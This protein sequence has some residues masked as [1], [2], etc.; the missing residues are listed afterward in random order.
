MNH[1]DTKT[2]RKKYINNYFVPLS[3]SGC[4]VVIP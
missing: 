2:L 4:L 1:K 3:L